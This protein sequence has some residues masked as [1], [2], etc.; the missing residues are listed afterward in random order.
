MTETVQN[1]SSSKA[2]KLGVAFSL[3]FS[4]FIWVAEQYLFLEQQLL[5]KPEGVPF[6]YFWQLNEPNFITRLSAWGLYIGHQVSIWWLIYAA[7]KERPQYTDGLHWFNIAALAANAIFI[8]LHLIQTA[9][10]YDGLAQDVIE[11]SAQWSV[12]VLLFVVLMMENQRRGMFFGKK[13][14]FVTAAS[15]GVEKIPR[16]L[17]CL[18]HNLHLLVSPHGRHLRTHH[19]IFIHVSIVTA[20]QSVFHT[21][22]PKP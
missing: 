6:W 18:G 1:I 19:G 5:P 3:V 4:A 16:V 10:W 15:T 22:S 21:C 11:Q 8:T 17:L 14:N 7:Q 9:I 2:L 20:R 12:I 13:L